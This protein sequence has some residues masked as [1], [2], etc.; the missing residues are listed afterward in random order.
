MWHSMLQMLLSLVGILITIFF[1]IGIHEFCHFLAARLLGIKVLRFSIGF[2]K[3]LW[4]SRDKQGTEY[5]ISLLPLGGYVKMLDETEEPVA[6]YEKPYAFNNQPFYKKFLVVI[7]GPLSNIVAA[8]FLYWL[9]FVIGFSAPVPLIGTIA[10][11]SI[12]AEAGLKTQEEIVSV[13]GQSTQSWLAALM[14]IFVHIGDN[15][16]MR[17]TL[18]NPNT[19]AQKTYTLNLTNWHVDPLQ[20]EPLQ[21][22]GITP[23]EPLIPLVIGIISPESPAALSGLKIGDKIIAINKKPITHWEQVLTIVSEH[24]SRLLTFAVEREKQVITVVVTT[25]YQ[26]TLSLHKVGYLG[27]GP[28]VELPANLLRH[29]QYSPVAAVPRAW[30]EISDFVQ[31]NFMSIAKL[32]EGKISLQSLGGPITIFTSAGTAINYGIVPFLSFLAFLNIAIGVINLLPIPG[33]DGGHIVFQVI[34][35]VIGRPVPLS[36]QMFCYRLGFIFL[37][38]IILQAIANDVMRLL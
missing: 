4:R 6:A 1:I 37:L 19:H 25:G 9:I 11:H 14:R 28:N 15:D 27:I 34:E 36:I 10:P 29:I 31:F 32:L 22:L 17:I 3:V 35:A 33:L 26:R 8:F 13:D 7:A 20:P 16:H 12:A 38:F 5:V 21:S 2:G 23:Y 30:Q 18:Q 24:P